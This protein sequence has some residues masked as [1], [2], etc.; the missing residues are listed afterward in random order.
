MFSY[1]K[2]RIAFKSEVN[3]ILI[4]QTR[5]DR[6]LLL[7]TCRTGGLHIQASATGTQCGRR[8]VGVGRR[9]GARRV[10]SARCL[11]QQ[12]LAHLSY[13][14]LQILLARK[15]IAVLRLWIAIGIICMSQGTIKCA[16]NLPER[17]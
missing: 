5:H 8:R 7:I 6:K 9:V 11:A 12:L 15:D 3:S 2:K 1:I 4:L 13:L 14:Q 16:D 17:P 10:W